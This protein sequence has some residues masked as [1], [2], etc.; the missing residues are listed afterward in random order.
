MVPLSIVTV[1]E[2]ELGMSWL[3]EDTEN[4]VP[5]ETVKHYKV[6]YEIFFTNESYDIELQHEKAQNYSLRKY[7]SNT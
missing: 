7:T 3:F 4:E 5:F 2:P 1:I 6:P